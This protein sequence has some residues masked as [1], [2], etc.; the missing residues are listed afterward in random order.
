MKKIPGA[1]K[2]G[3]KP[4]K[5]S[6]LDHHDHRLYYLSFRQKLL[7]QTQCLIKTSPF[8]ILLIFQSY[9]NRDPPFSLKPP[10]L[11]AL[12]FTSPT[13]TQTCRFSVAWFCWG[14]CLLLE[15]RSV[16]FLVGLGGG[17]DFMEVGHDFAVCSNNP[18]P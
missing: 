18:V 17:S 8:G 15:R 9:G 16:H 12:I 3:P 10:P 1:P 2:T 6:R 5:K 4:S 13:Q 7:C 14:F 11:N